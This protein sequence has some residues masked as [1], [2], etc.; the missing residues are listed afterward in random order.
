VLSG[1]GCEKGEATRESGRRVGLTRA[2]EEKPGKEKKLHFGG[3]AR[4][5]IPDFIMGKLERKR[6]GSMMRSSTTAGEDG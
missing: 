4:R 1:K 2:S 6:N 3:F 5:N